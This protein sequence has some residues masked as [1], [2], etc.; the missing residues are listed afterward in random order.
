[1]GCDCADSGAGRAEGGRDG[2]V[3]YGRDEGSVMTRCPV[4][5]EFA[6]YCQGHGE[7][8]D[9]MG[10]TILEQHEDGDHS[11]CATYDDGECVG[12]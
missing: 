11:S 3:D 4:C 6:D 9:P 2:L 10:A 7:I 1:M 8:G 5:G 12:L